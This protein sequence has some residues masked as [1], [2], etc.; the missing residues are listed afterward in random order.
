MNLTFSDSIIL[1]LKTDTLFMYYFIIIKT[2]NNMNFKKLNRYNIIVF[3]NTIL[4]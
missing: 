1:F 2:L 4:L 3:V